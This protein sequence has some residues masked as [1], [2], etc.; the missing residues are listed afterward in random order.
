LRTTVDRANES[1]QP[2]IEL[3]ELVLKVLRSVP[4][5]LRLI[6]QLLLEVEQRDLRAVH[7]RLDSANGSAPLD[8][9]LDLFE[10]IAESAVLDEHCRVL[11]VLRSRREV[12]CLR[13]DRNDTDVPH[14]QV[15]TGQPVDAI[16]V[17][18][19][20]VVVKDGPRVLQKATHVHCL[21]EVALHVQDEQQRLVLLPQLLHA[22]E[23]LLLDAVGASKEQHNVRLVD[24]R[25]C[26]SA[27]LLAL[28]SADAGGIDD[29]K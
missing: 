11:R 17:T 5:C 24:Y 21:L 23:R 4:H 27:I 15:L 19:Q 28:V 1:V 18:S 22:L 20:L 2:D 7:D 16:K 25:E 3:A 13:V 10:E 12:G 6:A 9:R 29:T 14:P 8:L 26:L